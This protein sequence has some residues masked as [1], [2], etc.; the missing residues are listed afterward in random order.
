MP[1]NESALDRIDRTQRE[2]AAEQAHWADC[3]RVQRA[4]MTRA[5]AD[6]ERETLLQALVVD[7]ARAS[8][9]QTDTAA[10]DEIP[11]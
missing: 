1:F 7:W 5:R 9:Q 4:I 3:E 6:L 11:F 8:L 2:L 10:D